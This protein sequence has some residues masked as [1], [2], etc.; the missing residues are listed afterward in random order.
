MRRLAV[1]LGLLALFFAVW[2]TTADAHPQP[3]P[4]TDKPHLHLCIPG[5]DPE[6][7]TCRWP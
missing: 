7:A 3:I 2:L 6:V 4:G 5:A 1:L